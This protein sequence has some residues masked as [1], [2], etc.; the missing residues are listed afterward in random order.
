MPNCLIRLLVILRYVEQKMIIDNDILSLD[1]LSYEIFAFKLVSIATK[2]Y[3]ILR[4]NYF[5]IGL[6]KFDSIPKANMFPKLHN[7]MYLK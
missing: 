6:L 3:D 5:D 4:C 7:F 1:Y 2:H